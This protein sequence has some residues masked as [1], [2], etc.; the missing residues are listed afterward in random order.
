MRMCEFNKPAQ[1]S[2]HSSCHLSFRT[3]ASPESHSCRQIEDFAGST[4]WW[5]EKSPLLFRCSIRS[6]ESENE[7]GQPTQGSLPSL[8]DLPS[9]T[10]HAKPFSIIC[11]AATKAFHTTDEFFDDLLGSL[12]HSNGKI[13]SMY[14]LLV[15][16][17]QRLSE[18]T[19][20]QDNLATKDLEKGYK[21]F[22]PHPPHRFGLKILSHATQGVTWS[23]F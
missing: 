16:A 21:S 5:R 20:L 9:P 22:I 12:I 3:R 15:T 8:T 17:V 18:K 23:F 1:K 6:H 2:L 13:G 14:F 11:I 19:S 7:S 4:I 10:F